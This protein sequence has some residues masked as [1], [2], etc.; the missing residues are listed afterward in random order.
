MST[1]KHL[2][3]GSFHVRACACVC[4]CA[5]LRAYQ[6][7]MRTVTRFSSILARLLRALSCK[8]LCPVVLHKEE[9]EGKWE[10]ERVD[11]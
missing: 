10:Y 2:R 5:F 3:H 9:R 8:H 11:E 7:S 1:L 4:V 6:R